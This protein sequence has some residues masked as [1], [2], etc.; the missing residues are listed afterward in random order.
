MGDLDWSSGWLAGSPVRVLDTVVLDG[1]GAPRSWFYTSSKTGAVATKDAAQLTWAK[2]GRRFAKFALASP[3]NANGPRRV[4][5]LLRRDGARAVLGE[6]ELAALVQ[7]APRDRASM[8]A[9][10][11]GVQVYLRPGMALARQ[12][13]PT[14]KP[15]AG[16]SRGAPMGWRVR[17]PAP[18]A[19]P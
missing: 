8:L 14:K 3:E 1:A 17:R 12:R 13:A 5:V 18:R 9:G 6:A 15:G 2:I 4:A 10:V 7:A 19:L 11:G 16:Q